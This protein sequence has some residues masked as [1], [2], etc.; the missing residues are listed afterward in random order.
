MPE[1]ALPAGIDLDALADAIAER[2]AAR[3]RLP[4]LLDQQAA[5]AFVGLSRSGWFRARSAGSL[6]KPVFIEGNGDRWRRKD[7]E[8]WVDRQKPRRSRQR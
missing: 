5:M 6:P 2:L 4:A 7:L 8:E 1:T 3:T